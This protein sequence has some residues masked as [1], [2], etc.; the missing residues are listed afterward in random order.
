MEQVGA[1]LTAAHPR[2]RPSLAGLEQVRPFVLRAEDSA[3]GA[4]IGRH[5]AV[6]A[7]AAMNETLARIPLPLDHHILDDDDV[8]TRD[9]PRLR[10]KGGC[11]VGRNPSP[12]FVG[13][14]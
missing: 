8:A 6:L 3:R 4:R 13:S 10:Q 1:R 2:H 7:V 14:A 12:S 5:L 9:A 11:V